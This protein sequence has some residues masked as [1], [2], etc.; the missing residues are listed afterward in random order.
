MLEIKTTH[1][2]P[3]DE[4][5]CAHALGGEICSYFSA[6]VGPRCLLWHKSLNTLGKTPQKCEDCRMACARARREATRKGA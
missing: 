5:E 4:Y 1:V 2:V 6:A 3:R